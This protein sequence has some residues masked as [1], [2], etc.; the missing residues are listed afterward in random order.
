MDTL[1]G[2][3]PVGVQPPRRAGILAPNDVGDCS[4]IGLSQHGGLGAHDRVDPAAK[5]ARRA[6]IDQSEQQHDACCEDE[7]EQAGQ[8]K[9]GGAPKI[10]RPHR[11]CSLTRA[12]W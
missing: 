1:L 6:P 11:A 9:G 4:G 3:Q 12:P 2:E 7:P 10:K 5:R 8:A